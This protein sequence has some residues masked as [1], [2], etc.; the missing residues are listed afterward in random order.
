MN[1]HPNSEEILAKINALTAM[2]EPMAQHATLRDVFAAMALQ[3]TLA[4]PHT[5]AI[6]VSLRNDGKDA[7][8]EVAGMSYEMA[9]AMLAAR[10]DQ[11]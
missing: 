7:A 2:N 1:M 10:K 4:A 3:G 9:D 11:P 6:M 5:A 8:A